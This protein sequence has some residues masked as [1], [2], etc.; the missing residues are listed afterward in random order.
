MVNIDIIEDYNLLKRIS[1]NRQLNP[2]HIAKLEESIKKDPSKIQYT[3]ILIN[4]KNEII[5]GQHRFEAI[6]RLGL[7]VYAIKAKGMNLNNVQTLNSLSRNWTP[8]DYAR[9]YAETGNQNYMYYLEF[10]Q[11]Y[12]FTHSI[13]SMY[14]TLIPHRPNCNMFNE[15]KFTVKDTNESSRLLDQLLDIKKYYKDATDSLFAEAFMKVQMN[16]NYDHER[17]VYKVSISLGKIEKYARTED[18]IRMLE[19]IY[20]HRLPD[21]QKVRFF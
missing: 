8:I 13:I 15:G 18:T 17:M 3:P 21:N 1:G 12:G 5:D 16:D 9:C 20:N 14:L 6:K 11:K 10:K 19:K 2:L 7:P 4:D